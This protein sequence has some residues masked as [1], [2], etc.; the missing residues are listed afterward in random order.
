M[1]GIPARA[2]F[3]PPCNGITVIGVRSSF[4]KRTWC[5]KYTESPAP[6]AISATGTI[7]PSTWQVLRPKWISVM[8]RR[9]GASRQPESLTRFL[10]S[11]GA[12]HVKQLRASGAF[13]LLHHW[14][15]TRV[16]VSNPISLPDWL[17]VPTG[18]ALLDR[19]PHLL[20][21][22]RHV[23]VLHAEVAERV[24]HRVVDRR[25]RADRPGLADP[26][27]AQRVEVRRGDGP[28]GLE[29][30]QLVCRRERVV[31]QGRRPRVAVRV[32]H[33]LLEQR[34]R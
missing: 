5:S 9:R 25:G 32:V 33:H 10:M 12:P 34:L 27:H 16:P 20:R 14:H 22:E 7:S 19:P 30:G 29:P 21:C 28:V 6:S 11:S 3:I 24:E 17:L 1:N 23:E 13:W 26:L 31:E 8:S 15:S 2:R 18:C 4:H